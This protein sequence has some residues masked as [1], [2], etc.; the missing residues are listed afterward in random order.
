[1][2]RIQLSEESIERAVRFWKPV[3]HSVKKNGRCLN[4]IEAYELGDPKKTSKPDKAP[5]IAMCNIMALEA[6]RRMGSQNP[7][8]TIVKNLQN[9]SEREREIADYW[10]KNFHPTVFQAEWAWRAVISVMV[11]EPYATRDLLERYQEQLP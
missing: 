8:T 3:Y 2:P 5:Y 7:T 9:A 4:G 11:G 6:L 10:K 1:M